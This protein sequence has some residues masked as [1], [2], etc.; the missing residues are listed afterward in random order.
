MGS[1]LFDSR[2]SRDL[3]LAVLGCAMVASAALLIWET[4]GTTLAVDEWRF[5]FAERT[6]NT[7][8]AYFLPHNGHLVAFPVLITKVGLQ[9]LGTDTSLPLH[10]LAIGVHLATAGLLFVFLRRA[11]GAPLALAPTVLFLFLGAAGDAFVGSHGLSLTL[12]PATGL[13]AWLLMARRTP[14][15]D[16]AAAALLSLGIL[17]SGTALPFCFG[18]IALVLVDRASPRSQLW[19]PAIPLAIY[20]FWWLLE[21]H[22]DGQLA[23]DNLGGL[24][25][26]L[27]NSLGA[28]LASIT[29]FFVAP[30]SHE[31]SFDDTA[32]QALAASFLMAIVIAL[33]GPRYRLPHAAVPA[34][35][36][37]VSFWLLTGLSADELRLPDSSRYLY[38]GVVLL[39]L[40]L[41]VSISA[42]SAWRRGALILGAICAFALLPNVRELIYA[43]NESREQSN[44]NRAVLGA[45]DL[46]SGQVPADTVI[47]EES[48]S[49]EGNIQDLRLSLEG[50]VAA[51]ERFGS[52]A[53]SLE[54][55]ATT[56]PEARAAADRFLI[57]A[58]PIEV[59]PGTGLR[60]PLPPVSEISQTGGELVPVGGCT[61]FRPLA[62]GAQVT[63]TL[64]V[65]GLWIQPQPGPST[66]I[67]VRRYGDE[68]EAISPALGGQASHVALPASNA[69]NGWLAQLTP[70]QPVLICQ[71]AR[72]SLYRG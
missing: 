64:P 5:G 67:G 43:G 51:R 32:G 21:G 17:S 1:Q 44:V 46:V 42:S 69:S 71:A 18:A 48:E 10:L 52:P 58:L 16:V 4:R 56:E 41:G 11:L 14:A 20:A 28:S 62:S 47:E 26:Y 34:L 68:F 70:E 57:R 24:P 37:L 8:S 3:A 30:G 63:L 35:V 66:A 38:I 49:D 6:D 60:R 22:N 33:F 36:A 65:G 15:A 23:I 45:A 54:E 39:L 9:V 31:P 29:G 72:S 55:I 27:F 7:L 53:F 13:S 25:S 2:G 61:S 40:V 59:I 12:A 50:Y 19:V